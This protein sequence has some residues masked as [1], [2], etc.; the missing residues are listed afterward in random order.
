[1]S[2]IDQ[3]IEKKGLKP[4][5]LSPEE[6]E[7]VKQW[8]NIL[9]AGSEITVDRIAQFCDYSIK[10][11]EAQFK[12]LDNTPEKTQRLTLLHSVYSSL[13]SVIRNP[14]AEK[15]ALVKYLTSLI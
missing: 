1:M 3:V 11:I 13:L 8:Q 12:N 2:I 14:Q 7:T 15:D 9:L 5:E 10:N 6:K 4:E